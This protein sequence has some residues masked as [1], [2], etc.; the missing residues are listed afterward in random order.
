M[1]NF[2]NR[3]MPKTCCF[4][5]K[6]YECDKLLRYCNFPKEITII[7]QKSSATSSF[8]STFHLRFDSVF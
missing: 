4:S 3:T 2:K 6:I 7:L 8:G 5:S 1:G